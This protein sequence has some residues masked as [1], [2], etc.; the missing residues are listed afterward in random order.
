MERLHEA[1]EM[2]IKH[3]EDIGNKRKVMV[4]SE[5]SF[6]LIQFKDDEDALNTLVKTLSDNEKKN[7]ILASIKK[8]H[9]QWAQL[10]YISRI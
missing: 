2:G 5:V 9:Y 8:F 6:L 1:L 3:Y 7:Q 10:Q 4:L